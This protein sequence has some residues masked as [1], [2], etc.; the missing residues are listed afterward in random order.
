MAARKKKNRNS[1]WGWRLLGVA[2]CAFF[3]LG[4]YAGLAVANRA[5]TLNPSG[6]IASILGKFHLRPRRDLPQRGSDGAVAVVERTD[7]FYTLSAA[8]ELRGPLSAQAVGDLAIISG[9]GLDSMNGTELLDCAELVVRAE[10][11]LSELVSEIRV[12]DDGVATLFLEHSHTILL[13][14][15]A[16]ASDELA[17]AAAVM[18]RWREHLNLMTALDLTTP[19]EAVVRL[20]EPVDLALAEIGAAPRSLGALG[21]E[22]S[23]R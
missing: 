23:P 5:R 16:R 8:G 13:L 11:A 22:P 17:H 2:L 14:D 12:A 18:N 19:G 9:P 3:G 7:G 4:V 15:R 1:D 6:R 20:R 10:G 21:R